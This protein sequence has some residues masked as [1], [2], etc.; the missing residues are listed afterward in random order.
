MPWHRVVLFILYCGI[1]FYDTITDHTTLFYDIITQMKPLLE[2]C[3]FSPINEF[4]LTEAFIVNLL[5][6]ILSTTTEQ[7]EK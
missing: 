2:L 5:L 7:L 6:Y 4:Y 1:I 3:S